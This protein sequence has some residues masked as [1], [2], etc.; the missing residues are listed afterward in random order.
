MLK[1][2]KY[3]KWDNDEGPPDWGDLKHQEEEQAA[4]LK[5][6]QKVIIIRHLQAQLSCS[7]GARE[8]P[9]NKSPRYYSLISSSL[10]SRPVSN[11]MIRVTHNNSVVRA[12]RYRILVKIRGTE[13]SLLMKKKGRR[14]RR[15]CPAEK[16][17]SP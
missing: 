16:K 7:K 5:S 1:K 14:R 4:A 11:N 9:R 2:K 3:A 12:Y 15:F 10:I 17:K 8:S 6:V 13:V